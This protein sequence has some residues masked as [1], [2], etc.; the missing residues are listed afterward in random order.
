ML[1]RHALGKRKPDLDYFDNQWDGHKS[2]VRHDWNVGV[3]G[4]RVREDGKILRDKDW[5]FSRYSEGGWE[6]S[7]QT[8][9]QRE[10]G[11]VGAEIH[12]FSWRDGSVRGRMGQISEGILEEVW[13]EAAE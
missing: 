1:L 11:E 13:A 8:D 12:D 6:T 5:K 2:R 10:G 7:H 9:E 3:P 4:L